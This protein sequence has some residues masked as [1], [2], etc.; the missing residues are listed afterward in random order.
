MAVKDPFQLQWLC[1]YKGKDASLKSHY[2]SGNSTFWLKMKKYGLCLK[3]D[4]CAWIQQFTLA[5]S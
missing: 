2:F 4:L 1:E 3:L 5:S